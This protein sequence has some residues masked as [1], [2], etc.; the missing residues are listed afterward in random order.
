MPRRPD[1]SF[2]YRLSPR[3][4]RA[5]SHVDRNCFVP[6]KYA[7]EAYADYPLPI[8]HGQTISQPSLVAYMTEELDLHEDSRVLEI[9]TGCGYQTA[10]LSE[11]C[12][13]VYTIEFVPKLA[14]AAKERLDS[15]GYTNIHFRTGDGHIGWP[16]ATPFDAIIATAAAKEVPEPL[17]EQ[18]ATGGRMVIPIGPPNGSQILYMLEK[19]EDDFRSR[20]LLDVR[21]VPMVKDEA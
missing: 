7:S 10:L 2:R 16:E 3:V 20:K 11:L 19:E 14:K 17:K 1:F 5:V 15:L 6:E 21:F 12:A 9:G 8:G 4:D 13:E 18:L